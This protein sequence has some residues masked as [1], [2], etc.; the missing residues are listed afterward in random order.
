MLVVWD[1]SDEQLARRQSY[2]SSN[3]MAEK[4]HNPHVDQSLHTWY[5]IELLAKLINRD[6]LLLYLP[7]VQVQYSSNFLVDI[8]LEF[9]QKVLAQSPA[10]TSP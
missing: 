7:H 5:V 6:V 2:I 3:N 10:L 1:V 8:S 9:Q 4:L